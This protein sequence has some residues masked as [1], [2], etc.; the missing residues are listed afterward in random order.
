MTIPDSK[1]EGMTP[2]S[3]MYVYAT[4]MV[5][6]CYKQVPVEGKSVLTIIG[7]GDQIL[8]AYF[9]GARAV[10]GFD[11][12]T[13]SPLFVRLKI[14]AIEHLSYEEFVV[15]FGSAH[16]N[17]TFDRSLYEKVKKFLDRETAEFF[18]KVY[19]ES[20]GNPLKS[21]YFR[22][23][24]MLGASAASMNAYL[25]NE[26]AYSRMREML[27]TVSPEYI[28]G[29]IDETVERLPQESYDVVNM[30]NVLNYYV[31]SDKTRV[32]KMLDLLRVLARSVR[33][34]GILFFYSYS[35]TIYDNSI[36]H[37]TVPPAS[38]TE[39]KEKLKE[40]GIFEVSEASFV[41][42][43]GKESDTITLLTK[44]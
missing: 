37:D 17:G 9:F 30:S 42:T 43:N 15:F 5:A 2:E 7:S 39:T 8:N 18:D 36:F 23:R 38:S 28:L 40:L 16:G 12:N 19:T 27:K 44:I 11:I 34:G 32:G 26:A 10:T 4:E 22:E 3:R 21:S 13:R 25:E 1:K 31:G 35:P 14:A 24:S 41:G 33:R 20:E 29:A 6:S